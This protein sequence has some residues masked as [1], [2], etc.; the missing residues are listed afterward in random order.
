MENQRRIT[1]SRTEK[2]MQ[3]SN[4]GEENIDNNGLPQPNMITNIPNA[5][6]SPQNHQLEERNH[7]R[8][9]ATMTD[10]D[11]LQLDMVGIDF[12]YRQVDE[13]TAM[14]ANSRNIQKRSSTPENISQ[15]PMDNQNKRGGHNKRTNKNP[16]PN[17]NKK[18]KPQA[19]TRDIITDRQIEQFV[20]EQ[21][22]TSSAQ[23]SHPRDQPPTAIPPVEN[24]QS[25]SANPTKKLSSTSRTISPKR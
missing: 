8:V 13:E 4:V 2:T 14:D 1:R 25:E 5:G 16:S 10:Y 18:N 23:P 17:Q 21:R 6:P 9:P 12:L 22:I 20:H 3:K 24:T 15:I 11:P 19:Q 7:E